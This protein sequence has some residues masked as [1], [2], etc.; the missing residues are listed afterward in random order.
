[1]FLLCLL[2]ESIQFTS[3][4]TLCIALFHSD[5]T[6]FCCIKIENKIT[7][8]VWMQPIGF[9]LTYRNFS[10][11]QNHF[12]IPFDVPT[13]HDCYF[14]YK[15][16]PMFTHASFSL[17]S[18]STTYRH[19]SQ[20]LQKTL[21]RKDAYSRYNPNRG[22]WPEI[23]CFHFVVLFI[24]FLPVPNFF[25]Y[26]QLCF[27]PL[28]SN[29]CVAEFTCC[30]HHQWYKWSAYK[31]DSIVCMWLDPANLISKILSNWRCQNHVSFPVIYQY[32]HIEDVTLA[33]IFCFSKWA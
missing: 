28:L 1:M 30:I 33:Q 31:L 27:F 18:F 9:M 8:M 22:G 19:N 21:L 13:Y 15:H 12:F 23:A 5:I 14:V 2:N 11:I 6:I 29:L 24:C 20:Q 17:Y 26:L 32:I 10:G 4:V 16:T 25:H 3:D 7:N